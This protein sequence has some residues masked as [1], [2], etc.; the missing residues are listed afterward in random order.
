[1]NG[2]K[3]F[4]LAAIALL[5]LPV[6]FAQESEKATVVD[7]TVFTGANMWTT[8]AAGVSVDV[9][10]EEETDTVVTNSEGYFRALFEAGDCSLGEEVTACAGEVCD[11]R[12][13]IGETT[14]IN[15]LGFKLFDVPEFGAVAASLAVAGAGVGYLALR[16]RK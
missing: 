2:S 5:V 8:P 12:E 3:L 7:G 4:V 15:L 1:M 11:T 13:L 14:R 10:C 6:A 9:T 16:R